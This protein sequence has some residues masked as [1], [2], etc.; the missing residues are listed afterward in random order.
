[1][2][3]V[4][5]ASGHIGTGIVLAL[6]SIGKT[7]LAVGRE[8]V[9]LEELAAKCPNSDERLLLLPFDASQ[10]GLVDEAF[11]AAESVGEPITGWVNN[12]HSR[13]SGG[14]LGKIE[15]ADAEEAVKAL[16]D[17]VL[18]V[19]EFSEEVKARKGSA[20]IVNVGS[21]YGITSPYPSVYAEHPQFHNPPLYGAVK[22]GLIQFTRYA[23]VHLA[24]DGIRVNSVSPGPIPKHQLPKGFLK[25]LQSKSPL[26][27]L[28]QPN[29]VAGA[30]LFLLSE[31]SSYVLG[32]DIVVDGGWTS[33]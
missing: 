21:M 30:V 7:V 3:V 27:R 1:M 12:A 22:A 17:V 31:S 29:D 28:G 33:W 23:A 14:L 5:G 2:I 16:S 6:L 19:S 10:D 11:V 25:A 8:R 32:H 26:G 20:S 15:R 24:Q 18:L 9:A 4:T 13:T